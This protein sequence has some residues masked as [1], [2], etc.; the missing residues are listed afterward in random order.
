MRRLKTFDWRRT[1]QIVVTVD[2]SR[3]SSAQ[4]AYEHVSNNRL[5]AGLIRNIERGK[6]LKNK[7]GSWAYIKSGYVM[8]DGK[9]KWQPGTEPLKISGWCW[10]LEWHKNGFPH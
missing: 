9:R 2:P 4:E 8:E 3:F 6:K 10:F 5:I 1:R 7:D